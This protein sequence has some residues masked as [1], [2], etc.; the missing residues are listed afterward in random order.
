MKTMKNKLQPDINLGNVEHII[1]KQIKKYWPKR[2]ADYLEG[3]LEVKIN[4][5]ENSYDE[6]WFNDVKQ[7]ASITDPACVLIVGFDQ[8]ILFLHEHMVDPL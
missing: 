8:A 3:R 6:Q 2:L 1:E 7:K 5:V 4:I